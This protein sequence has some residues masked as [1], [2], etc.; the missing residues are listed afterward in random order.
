M[1]KRL[2]SIR[3]RV[4]VGLSLISCVV[5]A[6]VGYR[7]YVEWDLRVEYARARV[8]NSAQQLAATHNDLVQYTA[9]LIDSLAHIA[10]I[11][12]FEG[13]AECSRELSRELESSSHFVSI[14]VLQSNG[15]IACEATRSSGSFNVADAPYF[16][17]AL[18]TPRV[19]I[20]EALY[21]S[22][23]GSSRFLFTK[24]FFRRRAPPTASS[25]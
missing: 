11:T 12:R 1:P 14:S 15:K 25:S 22:S 17:Q 20:G 16:R 2:S 13:S 24:A 7:A 6:I 23:P 8:H 9:G 10:A 4:F 18:Q 19:V 21:G 3:L 5:V